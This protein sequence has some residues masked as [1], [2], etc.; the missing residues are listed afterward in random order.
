MEYVTVATDAITKMVPFLVD[1]VG[2]EVA[3]GVGKKLWEILEKAFNS[4]A[5]EGYISQLKNNPDDT[6]IQN[7]ARARLTELLE[8]NPNI[9][10]EIAVILPHIHMNHYT[11]RNEELHKLRCAVADGASVVWISGDEGV[12]KTSLAIEFAAH[13]CSSKD[14][15][16]TPLFVDLLGNVP[17]TLGLDEVISRIINE[18]QPQ[19]F[20]QNDAEKILANVF[21][22]TLSDKKLI[23]LLDDAK[24]TD[25]IAEMISKT[26]K[27]SCLIIVTSRKKC[28]YGYEW[29]FPLKVSELTEKDAINLLEKVSPELSA[30]SEDLV[31][32]CGYLPLPILWV[33]KILHRSEIVIDEY[34]DKLNKCT[35]KNI[36]QNVLSINYEYLSEENKEMLCDLVI[37]SGTF[38]T[39]ALSAIWGLTDEGSVIN[40]ISEFIDISMIG[41]DQIPGRYLLHDSVRSFLSK[42]RDGRRCEEE[43]FVY[44]N[45]FMNLLERL[46][47]Q[48]VNGGEKFKESRAL[49]DVEWNN[50]HE[51]Y[52]FALCLADEGKKAYQEICINFPIAG[53][54]ILSLRQDVEFR[55]EWIEK[56]MELASKLNM[57][58]EKSILTGLFA[59]ALR[60]RGS[61]RDVNISKT[62]LDFSIEIA[63]SKRL[64]K[65][66]GIHLNNQGNSYAVDGDFLGSIEIYENALQIFERK[67]DKIG[68]TIVLNNLARTYI[69][70]GETKKAEE[71]SKKAIEITEHTGDQRRRAGANIN[72][73]LVKRHFGDLNESITYHNEALMI[74]EN[75][76][77]QLWVAIALCYLGRSYM[78]KG[79]NDIQAGI[80][81]TKLA[82]TIFEGF[83]EIRWKGI[84]IGNLGVA[85]LYLEEWRSAINTLEDAIE[86]AEKSGDDRRHGVH[87]N[88]LGE[89]YVKNGQY[90]KAI[91][92][93]LEALSIAQKVNDKRRIA[94]ASLWLGAAFYQ[95]YI[96]VE[97]HMPIEAIMY[98]NKAK[99][100]S[101]E[102]G[103]KRKEALALR[104]LGLIE[105]EKCAFMEAKE[106]LGK[107]MRLSKQISKSFSDEIQRDIE[108]LNQRMALQ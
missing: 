46:N 76:G 45:H 25:Q 56:G 69:N 68:Q 11:G 54:D 20:L 66:E 73:G 79:G 70:L 35:N 61:R 40:K 57:I 108:A 33:G 29:V 91:D 38:D 17:R 63:K 93:N 60:H 104:Y 27:K 55:M 19:T 22:A 106:Y 90:K 52:Y 24:D 6:E 64:T 102:I 10:N 18:L 84:A 30:P 71:L 58:E 12:G 82:L 75:I 92:C 86:I 99:E 103:D 39:S 28:E 107:S 53:F 15:T 14:Y 87:C 95:Y 3:K 81:N 100:T 97:E 7:N 32:L 9:A 34:L 72:M 8:L 77:D 49:F 16:D 48:Y 83:G 43:M 44:T 37:F 1:K 89:A 47:A 96:G 101:S 85:Q 65:W 51:A 74:F 5:D 23:I 36:T 88:T 42:K 94:G 67:H 21:E 80:R 41:N 2:G 4:N 31:R 98:L 78:D 13:M 105:S 26:Y 62:L 50:I 59:V